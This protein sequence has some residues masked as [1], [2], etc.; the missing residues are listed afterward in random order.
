M[1]SARGKKS[2]LVFS[3]RKNERQSKGKTKKGQIEKV[4]AMER[5]RES[6]RERGKERDNRTAVSE[7]QPAVQTD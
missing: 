4:R 6:E 7:S 1:R 3:D 5:G 2:L